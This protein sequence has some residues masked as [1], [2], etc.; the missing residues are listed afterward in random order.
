MILFLHSGLLPFREVD[1]NQSPVQ[2][3]C[4]Q[5]PGQGLHSRDGCIVF[6]LPE[7]KIKSDAAYPIF[8]PAHFAFFDKPV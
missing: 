5:Q 1:S 8:E 2:G 7:K 3:S 4:S 6:Y